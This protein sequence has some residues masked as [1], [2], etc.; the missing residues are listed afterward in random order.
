[1][2]PLLRP[3]AL[4]AIASCLV[5]V[6]P[7]TA[8]AFYGFYVSGAD[9]KLHNDVTQVALRREGQRTV[10][11]MQ[12]NYQGPPKDL[13]TVVPVPVVLREQDVKTLDKAVFE[14]VGPT[15]T[16]WNNFEAR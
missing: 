11:S 7:A 16:S 15:I 3:F 10:L 8:E 2:A 5:L 4:S 9:A 6:A 12:N 13:A 1:M 14:R